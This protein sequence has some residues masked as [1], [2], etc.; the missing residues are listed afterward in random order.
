[1]IILQKSGKITEKDDKTNIILKFAVPKG[2][3]KIIIKYSYSPKILEN[4]E[5]AAELIE[6]CYDKYGEKITGSIADDMPVKNLITISVDDNGNYRGAAH[7][8]AHEQEHIISKDF[9]SPGF[10]KG[11][12]NSGEWD[13]MLNVH[14]VSCDVD[15]Q[16]TVEGEK[17]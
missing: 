15:Y 16:I 8:Q 9:A 10:L 13:I 11:E 7:R 4:R 17:E 3:E 14:S 5:K 1:M 2:I 6:N 12:I